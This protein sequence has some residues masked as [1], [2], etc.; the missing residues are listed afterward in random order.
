M[1]VINQLPHP[2]GGGGSETE[3][4]L[5]ENSSPTSAFAAKTVTLSDSLENYDKLRIYAI[6]TTSTSDH[7]VSF[8]VNIA[9]DLDYF[10]SGENKMAFS[11]S[12][13]GEK[14]N[15]SRIGYITALKSGVYFTTAYRM[16]ATSGHNTGYCIPVKIS[17]IK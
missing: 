10:V 17:G 4:V 9:E 12:M 3:T 2:K 15:Y 5:W 13:Q 6:R 14:Y 1:A 8:D 7:V 11:I 16:N